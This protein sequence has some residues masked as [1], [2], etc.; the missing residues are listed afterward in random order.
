MFISCILTNSLPKPPV[1]E[2]RLEDQPPTCWW[3]AMAGFRL[4]CWVESESPE[5]QGGPGILATTTAF[6]FPSQRTTSRYQVTISYAPFCRCARRRSL[7][8]RPTGRTGSDDGYLLGGSGVR[9]ASGARCRARALAPSPRRHG[10]LSKQES[11]FSALPRSKRC[12]VGKNLLQSR[13]SVS[14]SFRSSFPALHF[15]PATGGIYVSR[16]T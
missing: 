11:A 10:G 14:H 1:P 2:S 4:A 8:G 6:E 15:F 12:G 13:H 9:R 3:H 16:P 5:A 7:P